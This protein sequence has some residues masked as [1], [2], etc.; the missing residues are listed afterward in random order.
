[1][2]QATR[3]KLK[4]LVAEAEPRVQRDWFRRW[5][6]SIKTDGETADVT[7]NL[8]C[9]MTGEGVRNSIRVSGR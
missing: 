4:Q 9:L 2:L 5:I 7:Y 3:E 1:M 6:L 8:G